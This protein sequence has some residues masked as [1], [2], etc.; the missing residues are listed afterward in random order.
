[1]GNQNAIDASIV[2]LVGEE[3]EKKLYSALNSLVFQTCEFREIVLVYAA[4]CGH[5][6]DSALRRYSFS[7]MGI[8]AV[9][10]SGGNLVESVAGLLPTV[11]SEYVLV[12]SSLGR[13]HESAMELAAPVLNEGVDVALLP[14]AQKAKSDP[15]FALCGISNT[16][17]SKEELLPR[18]VCNPYWGKLWKKTLLEDWL[19]S[20]A[21][22]M[23]YYSEA[24]LLL[25]RCEAIGLVKNKR[26]PLYNH[27][28]FEGRSGD[29]IGEALVAQIAQ[30]DAMV[31]DA[32]DEMKLPLSYCR[33]KRLLDYA[34]LPCSRT[35]AFNEAFLRCWDDFAVRNEKG[36]YPI[37]EGLVEKRDEVLRRKKRIPARVFVA[38][39]QDD[40]SAVDEAKATLPLDGVEVVAL[41]E[42]ADEKGMLDVYD[43]GEVSQALCAAQAIY[44]CGGVF[45]NADVRPC[46]SFS[47]V[48]ENR[49]F[50]VKKGSTAV[51]LK[52]FGGEPGHPL[53]HELL[54]GDVFAGDD[55]AFAEKSFAEFLVG[56]F[57]MG[58]V[59]EPQL[60]AAGTQSYSW[61]EFLL[62]VAGAVKSYAADASYQVEGGYFVDDG[63]MAE[64]AASMERRDAEIRTLEK[65]VK[66]QQA[67]IEK[68]DK[69]IADVRGSLSWRVTEPIRSLH[70]KVKRS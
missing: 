51:S 67:K 9:E 20:H 7:S 17:L 1:M 44:E 60:L 35:D 31:E 3:D 34:T 14:V 68:M 49:A 53:F 36:Q 18:A 23:R 5:A 57:G 56:R 41:R 58:L 45:L 25:S 62:P 70:R 39:T 66:S 55:V 29:L 11:S 48:F 2:L 61:A 27:V 64:I 28:S 69:K 43:R 42:W 54:N 37:K 26:E 4:P 22:S 38:T 21:F 40:E 12:M 52:T 8:R 6:V 50:V 46:Q 33:M 65:K 30:D 19:A 47:E 63:L 13:L 16:S 32:S 10:C 15:G 59:G 24:P